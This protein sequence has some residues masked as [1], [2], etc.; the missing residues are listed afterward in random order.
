MGG[1]WAGWPRAWRACCRKN[2]DFACRLLVAS[3]G[4]FKGRI[5]RPRIWRAAAVSGILVRRYSVCLS[6]VGARRDRRIRGRRRAIRQSS[7]STFCAPRTHCWCGNGRF[8]FSHSIGPRR[9]MR[10]SW[11]RSSP[12]PWCWP[13]RVGWRNPPRRC[14]G[15]VHLVFVIV[16]GLPVQ[17]LLLLEPGLW[18]DRAPLY[19][20]SVGWAILVGRGAEHVEPSTMRRCSGRAARDRNGDPGAQFASLAQHLGVGAGGVRVLWKGRIRTSGLD[21]RTRTAGRTNG[22]RFPAQRISPMR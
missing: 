14:N 12:F 13:R 16:A 2:R 5:G 17:H 6:L 8:C 19:L 21:R 11:P 10:W 9:P 22:R 15:R 4:V 20:G 7:T 3:S 18:A 1:S